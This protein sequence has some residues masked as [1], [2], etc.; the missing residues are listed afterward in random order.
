MRRIAMSVGVIAAAAM[1]GLSCSTSAYAATGTLVIN[2]KEYHNPPGRTCIAAETL[3][4]EVSNDLDTLVFIYHTTDCSDDEPY[5][6]V[7]PGEYSKY[8]DGR[9]VM[10]A[11]SA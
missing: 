6:F 1:M 5:A 8:D 11:P 9:G 10:V 7:P 3:P 2:G 4:M